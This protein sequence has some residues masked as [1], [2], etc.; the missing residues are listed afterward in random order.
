MSS[1]NTSDDVF[2]YTANGQS[3]PKDVVS[4]RFHSNVIKVDDNAFDKC[5]VLREVVLN[6]GLVTIGRSL[7][8]C[9]H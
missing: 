1:S 6:E 7:F 5:S 9:D 8:D 2:E 3:V 4:V